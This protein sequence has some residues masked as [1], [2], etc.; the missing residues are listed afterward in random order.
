MTEKE[1]ICVNCPMGCR[2]TVTLDGEKVVSVAGNSCPRGKTYAEKECVSPERILTTTVRIN[3][4]RHRVLPVITDRE[5]PL[6]S[7]FDAMKILAD[8]TVD[9]PVKEGQ[10]I[11]ENILGSGANVAASRSMEK[12]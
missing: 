5:I 4:G 11:V 3:G 7:L 2:L 8:V 1:L 9:A 10:T 6:G 12:E